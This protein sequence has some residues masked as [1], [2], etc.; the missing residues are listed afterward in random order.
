MTVE[1]AVTAA[2]SGW[3]NAGVT[4][5]PKMSSDGRNYR[6][7]I[8]DL[9]SKNTCGRPAHGPLQIQWNGEAIPC[10]YDYNN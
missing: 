6:E 8:D 1:E 4:D 7:R 5:I 10:C 3:G 2:H 9:M